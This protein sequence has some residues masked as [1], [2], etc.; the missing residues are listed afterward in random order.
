MQLV[1]A[2]VS[3]LITLLAS[4]L[5]AV[6]QSRTEF[7][8]LTKQLEQTYTTS[9]FDKRLEVYPVLFKALNQLN[10]K[11]EYSSPDKQQL[12]EFQRQYDEW[13]SAHAI[14]LT[15][16]TAKVI[17]GYHNYLIEL[18]E[19]NYEGSI[20]L[21]QWIEIRNIQIVIGKFLRAEIGVF[22]TTAAGIP[23]LERPHVKAIIDQ[24]QRSSQKIRNRFG[25]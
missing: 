8:K 18:L 6:Y 25:Y 16:T 22:D 9:L 21:E 11:I 4:S 7:R 19:E 5:I 1:I 14:L 3:G 10:H 23:E 20:P 2:I 24:L 12:I 17:W 15:P 13:I